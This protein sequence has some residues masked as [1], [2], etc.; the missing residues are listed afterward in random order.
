MFKNWEK[1]I[2]GNGQ[3]INVWPFTE[4]ISEVKRIF[5]GNSLSG[6][7][8]AEIGCG[9][10]NNLSFFLAEDCEIFGMDFSPTAIE[11]A[12]DFLGFDKNYPN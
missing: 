9:T 10:G 1:D 2:Y 4:V 3:Q 11:I 7:N 12:K 5:P 6:K 8:V